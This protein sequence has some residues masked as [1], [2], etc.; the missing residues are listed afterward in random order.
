MQQLLR[1]ARRAARIAGEEG[2]V[3]LTGL[4]E[5]FKQA[6][7][8]GRLVTEAL[9]CHVGLEGLWSPGP[10]RKGRCRARNPA[11]RPRDI[12]KGDSAVPAT[13][14]SAPDDMTSGQLR[15]IRIS[16]S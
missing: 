4:V 5:W 14:R 6:A 2:W 1:T 7:Q 10:G 15:M 12:K 8:A 3:L 11:F 9:E 16:S 13:V